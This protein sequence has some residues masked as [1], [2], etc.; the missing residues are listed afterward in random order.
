[1]KKVMLVVLS[2]A[3]LFAV[4]LVVS[5]CLTTI[6]PETGERMRAVDPNVPAMLEPFAEVGIAVGPLF[7]TIGAAAAGILAGLLTAWRQVKPKLIKAQAESDH[8]HAA[9]SAVVESLESFKETNP[10]DWKALGDLIE[11]QL[12]QQGISP[13]TVKN[14]IRA[15]RG[16][17]PLA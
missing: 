1:M 9:A 5:G 8:Y 12:S 17:P 13:K 14:V 6:D 11:Y 10:D 4:A 3:L 16:L 15:L 7:G 2:V